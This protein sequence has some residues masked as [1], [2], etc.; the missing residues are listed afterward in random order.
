MMICL[1]KDLLRRVM[2]ILVPMTFF[3]FALGFT[4][5]YSKAPHRVMNP[6]GFIIIFGVIVVILLIARLVGGLILN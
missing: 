4:F 6:E 5:P 3:I 1:G 2:I